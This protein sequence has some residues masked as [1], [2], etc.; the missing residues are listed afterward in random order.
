MNQLCGVYN[1]LWYI[2]SAGV[3]S[4]NRLI[5]IIVIMKVFFLLTFVL[6]FG[7]WGNTWAQ[8]VSV[9]AKD[10]SFKSV[11]Q[12]V[13][14]QSGYSF[15][16][17]EEYF[18]N[19][20]KINLHVENTEVLE[21]LPL[22]FNGQPFS[23]SVNGKVV[24]AV[25]SVQKS[26]A[27]EISSEE[28]QKPIRGRVTNEKG[29]PLVGASVFVMDA[30]GKR[31]NVQTKTDK[32][33]HF[34]LWDV[35]VGT[36]L[37]I[38][39][40]GYS[41]VQIAVTEEQL[42]ALLQPFSADVDEVE[43][44]ST[45]YQKIPKE[46]ATG[47][48]DYINKELLD[49]QVSTDILGRL[50]AVAHGLTYNR[51]TSTS[52]T[53]KN[54][55]IRGVST[56][57]GDKGPLIILDN[58]PYEGDINNI[59]PNDVADI[60][61]LKDAA[62]SSIWGAR[63]GNGVIVINTK[64]GK[65]NQPFSIDFN[66]NFS[67]IAKPDLSYLDQMSTTDFIDVERFLFDNKYRFSD[68]SNRN[69]PPFTEVYEILFAE[70]AGRYT[71]GQADQLIE[72][73]KNYNY[74][75]QLGSHVYRRGFNQQYALNLS[76][77]SDRVGWTASTG[78]DRNVST[79]S[80]V[81]NRFNL[82]MA[83]TYR[84]VKNL[85]ITSSIYVTQARSVSGRD[86]YE[87]I[88]TQKGKL[89]PYTRIIDEEGNALPV[90]KDYR[91]SY[92]N[93]LM[94]Q[95]NGKLLDWNYYPL[96]DYQYRD[97]RTGSSNMLI[98]TGLRYEPLSGLAFTARYA[99]EQERIKG[100]ML[101]GTDSYSVRNLINRF[102]VLG[103]NGTIKYQLPYGSIMDR[104]NGLM[105]SHQARGQV[106]YEKVIADHM[107]NF[108]GGMEIRHTQ[109]EIDNAVIYGLDEETW[110][111]SNVDFTTLKSV[112][113]P[114]GLSSLIPNTADLNKTTRRFVSTFA[115]MGY[116]YK[117]RYTATLSARRDA[118]N[119]FGV[120]ANAKWRPLWSAGLRYE[121]SKEPFYKSELLPYLSARLTY[122]FS[123]NIHPTRSA[124]TTISYGGINPYS[125]TP[126][127]IV[128]E[129]ANPELKWEKVGMTNIAV[130]FGFKEQRLSGSVEYY[131]KNAD[132]LFGSTRI[133]YTTGISTGLIKNV[134]K[135]RG[136]GIDLNI[137]SQNLVNGFR[138]TTSLN[139]SYNQ[140]KIV[141]YYRGSEQG[142]AYVK[143][144]NLISSLEGK[145]VHAVFSY[146]WHGLDPV[147]GDPLGDINGKSS[148]NYAA[149]MGDSTAIA[150]LVYHGSYSPTIFGSLGN[151]FSWKGL[152][153]SV[154]LMYKM[155]YY[156][157]KSTINY[158][159][160]VENRVGHSD[161]TKRWQNPGDEKLTDVPSM[162]YPANPNRDT[163]YAGTEAN[164]RRGDHIRIQYVNLSYRFSKKTCDRMGLRG[165][166]VYL[167]MNNLGIIWR[168]NKE[169]IDP[170]Y[171]PASSTLPPLTTALGCSLNF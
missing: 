18:R 16:I 85:E 116:S 38:S 146:R 73:L 72:G 105:N 170:E 61:I 6:S 162:V 125:Q 51:S 27:V 33:G 129:F 137:N 36:K 77:G 103:S 78:Y 150:D 130:D 138:W 106:E 75:D 1:R 104:S 64:K 93:T 32:S 17:K 97:N 79:L 142:A 155:G 43:V 139:F 23:Y 40:L 49:Q 152:T 87:G 135:M 19:A 160:L 91:P 25:A 55:Q 108:L 114:V 151:D 94:E 95:S 169:G 111:G 69:R 62:A 149:I 88:T 132:D 133:D 41:T 153:L 157:R 8:K 83:N 136:E 80:S 90:M 140:E 42:T 13:Q 7:A 156:F 11:I 76:G 109:N 53:T 98:N 28:T 54:I 159:Q 70:R 89:P 112:L 127:A 66:T 63:A 57:M 15:I 65:F 4:K 46:R 9:R 144:P 50:E 119:L 117:S 52:S 67:S 126:T 59:N 29:E 20:R 143:S 92:L 121:L 34:E 99:F 24:S 158:S 171:L 74:F 168:A 44:V 81:Y 147:N 22:L 161:Y 101:R 123:G 5:K 82:R 48:Y 128:S 154:R 110:L 26:N 84:P 56:L 165:A 71:A 12:Q 35:K 14:R 115:N 45:G 102:S 118:S 148:K 10:A 31:T 166:Q 86:G 2:L 163:F 39:Y 167:N 100:R 124:L 21:L 30:L 60:T 141:K 58:F 131:Q 37:E 122:G 113:V 68:T 47:S 145:P 96:T 134:A 120:N 3:T 164:V 107:I